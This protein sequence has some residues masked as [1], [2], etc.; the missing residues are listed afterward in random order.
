MEDRT[1][2]MWNCNTHSISVNYANRVQPRHKFQISAIS[3]GN[4]PEITVESREIKNE[5]NFRMA[6]NDR[7]KWQNKGIKNEKYGWQI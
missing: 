5:K 3:R 7:Y 6:R 1:S 2:F 4:Y